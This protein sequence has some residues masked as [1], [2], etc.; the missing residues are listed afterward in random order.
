MDIKEHYTNIGTSSLEILQD[1]LTKNDLSKLSS[2]HSFIVDFGNWLEVLQ[3]RPETT[4]LQNAIK[5]YQLAILSNIMGLYQQSFMGLR[6]FLER[7]LIAVLFSAKELELN[8]WKCGERDT[9]WAE[10]MNDEQGLTSTT[11]ST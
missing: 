4:I 3:D 10:L 7:T 9:Y 11:T 6:F 1:S 2:N 5:E 8:L